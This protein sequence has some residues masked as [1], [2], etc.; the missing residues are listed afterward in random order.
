MCAQF[1]D[2]S[3]VCAMAT[4]ETATFSA[5]RC[6][7][8]LDDYEQ[9]AAGA[10][11]FV[12]GKRVLVAREPLAPHGPVPLLGSISAPLSLVF[13]ADFTDRDSG[14]ASAMATTIKN[15][16]L[17]K[18]RLLFRQL[19]SPQ[20]VQAH[21]AAEAS[22]AAH[23]QGRFWEYYDVLFGNPQAQDRA[24]LERYAEAAGLDLVRFR[25]ALDQHT[26]AAD[27]DADLELGRKLGI[28]GAPALYVNGK[29]VRVPYGVDELARLVAEANP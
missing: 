9:T 25:E 18:V 13:F 28:R 23:A 26:F 12:E 19:P 22:L 16:Y 4:A 2:S 1:G 27:V 24:A 15:L 29:P 3:D 10:L 7:A 6:L 17:G 11:R 21:L 5:E 8:M 14:R 20:N